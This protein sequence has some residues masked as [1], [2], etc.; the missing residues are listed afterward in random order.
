M[1]YLLPLEDGRYEIREDDLPVSPDIIELT[2]EQF[3]GLSVSSLVYINGEI[4]NA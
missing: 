4:V 1:K 3:N 2:T